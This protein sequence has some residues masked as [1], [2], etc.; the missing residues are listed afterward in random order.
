MN[1][2]FAP[3]KQFFSVND[4]GGWKQVNKEFFGDGGIWDRLFAKTR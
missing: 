2:R 4:F 1:D 3:V